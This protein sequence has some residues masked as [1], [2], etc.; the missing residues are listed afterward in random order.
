MELSVKSSYYNYP[1]R[2]DKGDNNAINYTPNA[3]GMDL[4]NNPELIENILETENLPELKQII[5]DMNGKDSPYMT[6]GC[7]NWQA[8]DNSGIFTYLEFSFR[9]VI[10]AN[11]IEFISQ[12]DKL[13][14]DWL[15]KQSDKLN[16]NPDILVRETSRRIHW[17]YRPFSYY[18]DKERNLIYM[19]IASREF[20]ECDLLYNYVRIFLMKHLVIP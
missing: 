12:I 17:E 5:I 16:V 11:N 13:F 18:D 8:N 1:F 15:Y 3:G 10:T 20:H 7:A 19:E 9:D 14:L 4:V 2:S 6:L